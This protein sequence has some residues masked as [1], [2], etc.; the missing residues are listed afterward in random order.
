MLYIPLTKLKRK[1]NTGSGRMKLRSDLA[2][3]PLDDEVV[4]F[5]EEAQCL[6]GLNASAAHLAQEVSA[7]TPLSDIAR[8]L[9]RSGTTSADEAANWIASMLDALRSHGMVADEPLPKPSVSPEFR[10][11]QEQQARR[12]AMMP[13]YSPL[14]A[15]AERR[16]RLLDTIALVRFARAEQAEVVDAALGHLAVSGSGEPTIL[17]EVHA[18]ILGSRGSVRSNI[19]CDKSPA[20]FTTGLHRLAPAVKHL[21]WKQATD[22]YDFLFYIH[23]GV[24]GVGNRCILLP[25]A[26]G[27]GKSSLTAALVHRGYRYLSDE[28][29]LIEPITFHVPPMPLAVCVKSTGW[30]VMSRYFP[31]IGDLMGHQRMDGKV[32]RYIPPA[33]A[34]IQQSAAQVSHIIFP[35]YDANTATEIRPI[36]RSVALARM[37]SE[38]LACG[39]LD[40]TNVNQLIRWIGQIDCYELPFASLEDAIALVEHIAPPDRR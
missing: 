12:I 38:C 21:L 37:M 36:G 33:P 6:V 34:T 35:R 15:V 19:Y 4:A 31:H 22:R 13:L 8:E 10:S 5:S 26:A 2:F 29:A 23:A 16:Y 20:E 14:E 1:S 24:V 30:D 17:I 28:V 7:G 3:L 27:S 25:A 18:A 39:H 40:R 9:T 32:V 11:Q